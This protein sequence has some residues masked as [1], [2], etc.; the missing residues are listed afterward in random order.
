MENNLDAY[1]KIDEKKKKKHEIGVDVKG[2]IDAFN[3]VLSGTGD[4]PGMGCALGEAKENDIPVADDIFLA[5]QKEF[6]V[7]DFPQKG[8]QFIL[9]SG[10]FLNPV[11]AHGEVDEFI[12]NKF[13]EIN[14]LDYPNGYMVDSE[15][16]VRVNDGRGQSFT[17]DRYI[18]LPK[19][20]T[21]EQIY[22]IE[23]WL[24]EY[25]Y[26]EISVGDVE[27]HLAQFT[28]D[29][30]INN[31]INRI[32]KYKNSHILSEDADNM[33]DEK[34]LPDIAEEN[35][36]KQEDAGISSMFID[37]INDCWSAIDNY[38]SMVVTLD[39]L[40]RHDF[41]DILRG[42]LE[43]R[44]K[45]VGALQGV[46]ELLSPAG[47]EIEPSKEE[48]Q[49]Q[50]AFDAVEEDF[51]MNES[52]QKRK[53]YA[54]LTENKKIRLKEEWNS[55]G[56]LENFDP[57]SLV[58]KAFDNKYATNS[59]REF[60]DKLLYI[61][62]DPGFMF[63]QRIGTDKIWVDVVEIDKSTDKQNRIYMDSTTTEEGAVELLNSWKNEYMGL[64][65]E[66][67]SNPEEEL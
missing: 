38:H 46:L 31:I 52:I 44:N 65:P 63:G 57:E 45:E 55:N 22:A 53:T 18:T 16:C 24:K 47:D 13:P 66:E 27:G 1:T 32:K 33:D 11:K 7:T 42:L 50:L 43:D 21:N 26:S 30:G 36:I 54:Q 60:N 61:N 14:I 64:V 37:A 40:D 8:A 59:V 28:L 25:P 56:S 58:K 41:D 48:A 35:I 67:E 15:N 51:Q 3:H 4:M 20:I 12:V 62:V 5:I 2:S 29:D 6:P 49:D 34:N 17:Y 23:D 9:P 10:R 19:V 39:S